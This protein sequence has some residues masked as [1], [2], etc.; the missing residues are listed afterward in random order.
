MSAVTSSRGMVDIELSGLKLRLKFE[1]ENMMELSRLTG[2]DPITLLERI[3]QGASSDRDAGLR[4][5]DLNIVVPLISAGLCHL[6]EYQTLSDLQMKRKVCALIDGEVAQARLSMIQVTAKLAAAIMPVF[7]QSLQAPGETL[8]GNDESK[9][10]E[11]P[12]PLPDGAT[13]SAGTG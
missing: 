5:S 11:V 6:D 7:V 1:S 4:A 12:G 8:D 3:R 10:T 2:V 13:N 9:P